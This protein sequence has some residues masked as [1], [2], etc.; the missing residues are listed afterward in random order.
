MLIEEVDTPTEL[1]LVMELVKVMSKQAQVH[2]LQ[3]T[4]NEHGNHV[5]CHN[6]YYFLYDLPVH[7]NMTRP[8]AKLSCLICVTVLS[9]LND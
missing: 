4:H 3:V 9:D 5:S 6:L 8:P 7:Q 2:S 1:Y